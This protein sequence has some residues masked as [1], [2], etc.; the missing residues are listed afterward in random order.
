MLFIAFPRQESGE[1]KINEK[2]REREEETGK[3]EPELI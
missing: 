1:K 2:K 3:T